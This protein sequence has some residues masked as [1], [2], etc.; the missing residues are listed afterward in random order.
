MKKERTIGPNESELKKMIAIINSTFPKKYRLSLIYSVLDINAFNFKKG[1]IYRYISHIILEKFNGIIYDMTHYII[2]TDW[3][4]S[5]EWAYKN[6]LERWSK[7]ERWKFNVAE[8]IELKIPPAGSLEE[9][10]FKLNFFT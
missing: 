8:N 1:P 2:S 7:L 10:C 9:L 3:F 4:D 6:T 5:K